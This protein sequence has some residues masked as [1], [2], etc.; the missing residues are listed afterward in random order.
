MKFVLP[1]VF[2]YPL[3][4]LRRFACFYWDAEACEYCS[5]I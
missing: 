3:D 1:F 5:L 4:M 2:Y